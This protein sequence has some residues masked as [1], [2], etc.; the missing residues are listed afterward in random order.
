MNATDVEAYFS[1]KQ[2]ESAEKPQDKFP[3][4]EAIIGFVSDEQGAI[5]YVASS[6]LSASDKAKVKVVLTIQ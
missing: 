1:Q 4:D 3:N 5:G 6:S 2:Y